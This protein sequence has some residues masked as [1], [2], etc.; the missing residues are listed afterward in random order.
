MPDDHDV[1]GSG[2]REYRP[3]LPREAL[4][5]YR[6]L[7][8][9]KEVDGGHVNVGLKWPVERVAEEICKAERYQAVRGVKYLEPLDENHRPRIYRRVADPFLFMR[10]VG[11]QWRSGWRGR[12]TTSSA[13]PGPTTNGCQVKAGWAAGI[14][15]GTGCKGERPSN[16]VHYA[17]LR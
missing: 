11:P 17:E 16:A 3:G 8:F 15:S 14:W 4:V 10:M 5:V 9:A 12:P 2:S 7:Y 13:F 6:E 1:W